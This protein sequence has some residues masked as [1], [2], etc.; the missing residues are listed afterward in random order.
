VSLAETATADHA[1]HLER[2]FTRVPGER[3]YRVEGIEGEVP[4]WLRGT[5][6][7]NGPAR[8]ARAGLA[9]RHWL[10]G[11]GMVCSLAFGDDGITFTNRFV[12]S[13]KWT[14]EEAAGCALYRTF[15]T[16]FPGDR[17]VRGIALASPVNVS[18]YPC[19]GHLLAFGEQGLPWALAP[20]TLETVGEH[21]FGGRLNAVSP[22]S[23]H[24]HVDRANGEMFNFGVSF[25][26]RRPVLH[27]Y[28]FAADGRLVYRR[29]H[30][31]DAPRSVHDFGLSQR[32][33]VFYLSPYLLAM[34]ALAQGGRTLQE[35]LVWRPERGSRL[36]VVRRE[37]GAAVADVPIGSAYCLHLIN[38]FDDGD[39]LVVDV[40]ELEEPVYPDYL[41]LPESLFTA[42]RPGRPVRRV[43]D[44][45]R[46]EVVEERTL[47]YHRACDFP[48][49]DLASP[50]RPY[51]DFWLLGIS[52][53]GRPGRK[54][55]DELV[56]LRWSVGGVAGLYR[57]PRGRYL[58][59]E[60]VAAGDP[61]AP[62]RSAVICQE[63]DPAAGT[64]AFLLFDAH[65]VGAGPI[66]RLPL[67]EPI[68]PLFH[69]CFDPAA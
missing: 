12:R 11:D 6:Y 14:E 64:A 38:C 13:A 65:R 68:P 4:P 23:A 3:S 16:A 20:E 26:A 50:G 54:F 53:T 34:D 43:I 45:V 2:L 67:A 39:R 18:V 32:H 8:F 30:D 28:R 44:L 5:Y 55:F 10:D 24:P 69:A 9:Y 37:D 15:G 52:A 31:L 27:L 47:D 63:L 46:G 1:P 48:S 21:S 33:A 57:A 61:A 25:A 51:D 42:V 17:L 59:G 56:H 40:V 41:G 49:L 22:F 19:C 66:A 35:C 36:R 60:P 29:R 58:G 62:E 7:V